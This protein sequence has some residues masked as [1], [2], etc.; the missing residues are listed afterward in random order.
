MLC[1]QTIGGN[2]SEIFVKITDV[3]TGI[4]DVLRMA[5]NHPNGVSN[6]LLAYLPLVSPEGTAIGC[7]YGTGRMLRSG[8]SALQQESLQILRPADHVAIRR[9]LPAAN[10][11]ALPALNTGATHFLQATSS[12]KSR[13]ISRCST[14]KRLWR[15]AA[16]NG[17]VAA[18]FRAKWRIVALSCGVGANYLDVCLRS[19]GPWSA[20]GP[21]VAQGI[22]DVAGRNGCPFSAWSIP[23]HAPEMERWFIVRVYAP[24]V[25]RHPVCGAW[26][27]KTYPRAGGP[28]AR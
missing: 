18:V 21:A 6:L 14:R 1:L 27:T 25:G 12:V 24:G 5:E 4:H 2:C 9:P 15:I 26:L 22:R 8:P 23:C 19:S 28:S 17:I 7:L 13:R 3:R 20:E 10:A 16:V 11:L